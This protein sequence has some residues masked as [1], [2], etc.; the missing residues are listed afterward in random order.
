MVWHQFVTETLFQD[1]VCL[2]FVLS[3]IDIVH[4]TVTPFLHP[5]PPL[6]L[7]TPVPQEWFFNSKTMVI[8][9]R[10]ARLHL[11]NRSWHCPSL[12][13]LSRFRG[14]SHGSHHSVTD[15]SLVLTPLPIVLRARP[16]SP[17]Y[18]SLVPPESDLWTSGTSRN[19]SL[20]YTGPV[21]LS[22][23][24]P[25]ATTLIWYLSVRTHLCPYNFIDP[26]KT[27]VSIV[28]TIA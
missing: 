11:Y 3:T 4:D 25:T 7:K 16:V 8:F 5:H 28:Q 19:P 27:S 24:R 14:S 9:P 18:P 20:R 26:H 6:T 12:V 2:L 13:V 23:V 22:P 10:S 17:S 15:T 21:T 1:P